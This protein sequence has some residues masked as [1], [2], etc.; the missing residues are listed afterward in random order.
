MSYTI[1]KDLTP[2]NHH[3]GRNGHEIDAI[4]IHI[5]EGSMSATRSWF[6]TDASDVSSTYGISKLGEIVQYVEED[7]T[8]AANGIVV[9]P[10]AAIVLERPGV[11]PNLYTISIEHEGTGLADLTDE[12]RKAS[13][14]LIGDIA[15][16]RKKITIDHRH[17]IPHHA[18][19]AN[20]TCPGAIDMAKLVTL[21]AGGVVPVPAR[22]EY[23]RAVFS[24]LIG[25]YL[26]VTRYVSDTDWS[27][28]RLSQIKQAATKAGA[29]L[30]QMPLHP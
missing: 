9:R 28:V 15:S 27:F 16:R 21:A 7:D 14:W 11:N 17:V 18:I 6:F 4:V 2:Y 1:K 26:I 25:E 24:K 29:P 22:A 8:H 23:P 3:T 13:A 5:M 19:R 30:S 12:Q 10:T 20:K